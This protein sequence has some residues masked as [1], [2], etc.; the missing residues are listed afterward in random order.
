MIITILFLGAYHFLG[1]HFAEV[2]WI[3][4]LILWVILLSVIMIFAGFTVLKSLFVVAAELSLLIFLAQSYCNVPNR[5]APGNEALNNLLNIGLL[6]IFLTF[7]GSLY[8]TL[9][10]Y[11]EKLGKEPIPKAGILAIALFLIFAV[12]FI[13]QLY[14]AI[15]PIISNLCIYK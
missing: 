12:L 5:S 4:N 13:S 11:N 3:L 10:E 1:S 2:M 7:C 15:Y 14:Q 9:R 6:Y 8:K